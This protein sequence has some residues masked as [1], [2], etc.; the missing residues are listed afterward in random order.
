VA[1]EIIR[2]PSWDQVLEVVESRQPA[3]CL[4]DIENTLAPY[5][6]SRGEVF[7]LVV[8]ALDDLRDVAPGARLVLVSN[9][10]NLRWLIS[11]LQP[12]APDVVVLPAA[13]KPWTR[14]DDV[15]RGLPADEVL[16]I[17]D[18]M[19]T[20]GLLAWRLRA[21]FVHFLRSADAEPAWPR[22]LRRAGRAIEGLI[23]RGRGASDQVVR[24]PAGRVQRAGWTH[25]PVAPTAPMAGLPPALERQLPQAP[26]EAT[27]AIP[28]PP[29]MM[30]PE[31]RPPLEVLVADYVA[32]REDDRQSKASTATLF[33]LAW[34]LLA[35]SVGVIFEIIGTIPEGHSWIFAGLPLLP[36]AAGAL[37]MGHS[38]ESVIRSYYARE[39]E[40]VLLRRA[41][42]VAS[43]DGVRFP[44]WTHFTSLVFSPRSERAMF[45]V[46]PLAMTLPLTVLVVVVTM[47]S[48]SKVGEPVLR[49]G[50]SIFYALLLVALGLVYFELVFR[51]RALWRDAQRRVAR[52]LRGGSARPVTIVPYLLA[53]RPSDLL[54][55]GLPYVPIGALLGSVAAGKPFPSWA[56]LGLVMLAFEYLLYQ[57]RYMINDM[58]DYGEDQRHAGRGGRT[59]AAVANDDG[60]DRPGRV[61]GVMSPVPP[62][63]DADAGAA[64]PR[65]LSICTRMGS[66]RIP[67]HINRNQKRLIALVMVARIA[68]GL[69][70]LHWVQGRYL[71]GLA[72]WYL[73]VPWMGARMPLRLLPLV[74][75]AIFI[76]AVPYE[77][78][79][80][81]IKA[82][83]G[84]DG[85]RSRSSATPVT[86]ALYSKFLAL[87]VLVGLGYSLRGV[88]GLLI[89]S[90]GVLEVAVLVPAAAFVGALGCM[91]VLMAWT[92]DSCHFVR[93]AQPGQPVDFDSKLHY[94]PLARWA[95]LIEPSGRRPEAVGSKGAS[96]SSLEPENPP[97]PGELAGPC[98]EQ[99]LCR[100]PPME[101]GGWRAPWNVAGNIGAVLA[102]V[103]AIALVGEAQPA[104]LAAA[105]GLSLALTRTTTT[106]VATGAR[107][108]GAM[109]L[110]VL[111]ALLAYGTPRATVLMLLAPASILGVV[112][113]YFRASTLHGSIA[114]EDA[115]AGLPV[116]FLGLV[117]KFGELV[118][119]ILWG[120][121]FFRD[122]PIDDAQP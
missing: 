108:F 120:A 76:I 29:P 71:P 87:Y 60:Q 111:A 110:A 67:A 33:G 82:G 52:K 94:A 13:R 24:H 5:A 95:G 15:L 72:S 50:A 48:L 6:A 41:G 58:R 68:T 40:T 117:S 1:S 44:S 73:Q 98:G 99:A 102:A 11:S 78:I 37:A 39:L 96:M 66:V 101:R 59:R 25:S 81:A 31:D 86:S 100:K 113:L 63:G 121:D 30:T 17:G 27:Q 51:G 64:D 84:H 57:A 8:E 77:W 69:V 21:T 32:T 4:L 26:G 49:Y 89:G 10:R 2:K 54:V 14:L 92:V 16:V 45:R 83:Q 114:L 62:Q 107:V 79:K 35:A 9:S 22:L 90:R 115:I 43:D 85:L 61:A 105:G 122:P 12:V 119:R 53:P 109:L 97:R 91:F 103:S 47:L 36:L 56:L 70:L 28:P 106:R 112:H 23:F 75:V 34:A 116:R 3:C 104:H 19:V 80:S 118:A 18:Q 74:G 7:R 65:T 38:G 93:K 55:K 42:A 46:L 88:L 20:D